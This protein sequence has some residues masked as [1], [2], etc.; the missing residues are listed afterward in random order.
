VHL[1]V[2]LQQCT[3]AVTCIFLASSYQQFFFFFAGISRS[4][5]LFGKKFNKRSYIT[6]YICFLHF[7]IF[8]YSYFC[9]TIIIIIIFYIL[10]Y[11]FFVF[12]KSYLQ[13]K[14]V[15]QHNIVIKYYI[16]Y[17]KNLCRVSFSH[18]IAPL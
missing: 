14:L 3:L 17:T 8:T 5:K 15:E 9:N 1:R 18:N 16:I 13:L 11:Y 6:V 2:T 12:E 7:Y 4:L 10:N